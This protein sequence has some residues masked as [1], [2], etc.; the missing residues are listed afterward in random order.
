MKS[1]VIVERHSLHMCLKEY[2]FDIYID[3]TYKSTLGDHSHNIYHHICMDNKRLLVREE[4]YMKRRIREAIEIKKRDN[5][6]NKD[7]GLKLSNVGSWS[8]TS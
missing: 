5:T 4:H 6:L 7:K 1:C 8:L 3:C 2:T